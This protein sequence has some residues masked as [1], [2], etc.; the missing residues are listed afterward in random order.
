MDMSEV[1][2]ERLT[3]AAL[4][5]LFE[6]LNTEIDAQNTAWAGGGEL[7]DPAFWVAL[8]RT[9]PVIQAEHIADENFYPG[10]VPSLIDAPVEKYPNISVMAYQADP[11]AAQD[12]WADQFSVKVA[13]EIMVKAISTTDDRSDPDADAAAAEAVNMRCHRTLAAVKAVMQAPEGRNFRGLVPKVGNTPAM[14]VTNVFVRH[15][16]KGRGLRWFWQGARLDFTVQQW[17]NF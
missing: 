16:E 11:L 9:N 7:D 17:V 15:E 2:L 14:L 5:L 3:R 8:N 4:L 13:V 10:H 12:D 1:Q 6:N